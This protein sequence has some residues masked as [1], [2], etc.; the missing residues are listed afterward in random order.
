M[1]GRLSLVLSLILGNCTIALLSQPHL[2]S[3]KAQFIQ[4]LLE[5]EASGK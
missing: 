5:S 3:G 4:E 1:T 2:K